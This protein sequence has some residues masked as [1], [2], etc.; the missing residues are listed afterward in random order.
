MHTTYGEDLDEKSKEKL[1]DVDK[2]NYMGN[3]QIPNM[4]EITR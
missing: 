1:P 4:Q 2:N 3:L